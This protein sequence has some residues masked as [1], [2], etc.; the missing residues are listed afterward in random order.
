MREGIEREG[1]MPTRRHRRREGIGIPSEIADTTGQ[2]TELSSAR[3]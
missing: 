1:S 2:V 3:R